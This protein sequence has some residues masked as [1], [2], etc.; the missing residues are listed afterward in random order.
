MKLG[1]PRA[2]VPPLDGEAR[3]VYE[4]AIVDAWESYADA[5][6]AAEGRHV[7]I[8]KE[9]R[10]VTPNASADRLKA[11]EREAE[12]KAIETA[13][14]VIP[15]AAFTAMVHTISGLT[16]YRLVRMMNAS[17]TP[18]EA[19]AGRSAR[20]SMPSASTIRCSSRRSAIAPLDEADVPEAGFRG[21]APDGDAFAAAFDRQLNGRVAQLMD[22]SPQRRRR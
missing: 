2:F 7:P 16:L 10:H 22:A 18:H 8:L 21:R 9:L 19:R 1:E 11:I 15:L 12:K 17:D 14:Y 5:V 13:R 3:D 20:W 6:G 4:R